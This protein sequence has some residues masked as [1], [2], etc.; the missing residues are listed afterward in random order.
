MINDWD[1]YRYHTII[2]IWMAIGT[3]F[4]KFPRLVK[5]LSFFQVPAI[6]GEDVPTHYYVV[7]LFLVRVI[8]WLLTLIAWMVGKSFRMPEFGAS[9]NEIEK[10]RDD[11][12]W[13]N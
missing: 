6:C 8:A 11:L 7:P 12:F 13:Q 10:V 3:F 5:A 4:V 9:T 1:R 2:A